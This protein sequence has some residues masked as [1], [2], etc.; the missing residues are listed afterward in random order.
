MCWTRSSSNEA[1]LRAIREDGRLQ[2]LFSGDGRR[3]PCRGA[4]MRILALT[5]I[6]GAYDTAA[7]IL[8]HVAPD[9]LIIGGDLTTVGSVAEAE[10]A[11]ARFRSLVPA[12]FC[13]AGNMDLPAH[14]EL[15]VRMGIS[16]DGRGVRL[17]DVGLCG[18]SAAPH[19][20]LRTPHER[21]EEEIERTLR[22]GHAA[23]A[24]CRKIIFVPHAPGCGTFLIPFPP[25][26]E[27]SLN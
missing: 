1:R 14:D 12:L 2:L 5:D 25:E 11:L 22:A 17:G 6:H 27:D 18:A 8:Q 13:V 21:S 3:V 10:G 15:F 7:S 16:L 20:K 23:L 9:L 26:A 19:S 24:G 4:A